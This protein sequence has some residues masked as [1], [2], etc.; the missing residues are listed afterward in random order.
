MKIKTLLLLFLIFSSSLFAQNSIA[1]RWTEHLVFA[2]RNDFARPTVHSRNLFHAS[3]VMYDAWAAYENDADFYLLGK[4]FGNFQ[5]LYE[6]VPSVADK[7]AAQEEAISFAMYRLLMHRFQNSP[8]L[9]VTFANVNAF[10]DSLGY[11]KTNI[12][13][14][15]IHGGPAELGNY[16]ADR[17]IAYGYLDGSNEVGGYSN[18]YYQP[19]QD[20][21]QVEQP[22]NPNMIDPNHWQ[23]I[24]LSYAVDQAGNVLSSD[25]PFLS[26]EWGN[27]VPFALQDSVKSTYSRAGHNYNVYHDPGAPASLDTNVV[28]QLDSY[29]KWNFSLVSV[30]QSHLDPADTTIWDI[31]PASLGNISTYPTQFSDYPNFYNYF[32]GGDI[33]QGYAL[34]PVTGAPYTPQLVKRADYARVIAEFWADGLSSETPPGHW[35]VIYNQVSNHPLYEKKWKGQGATLNDLEYDVKAYLTLGGALYD[36]GICAWGIKGWYDYV[37]PVSAL[38]YMAEKGQSS[39][40]TL[41][42]YHPA[43]LPLVPGYIEIVELGDPLAGASNQHVGKIKLYTWKGPT[44]ISN[45]ATTYAGVDWI[46][47]ENWW[48]YQRP[49]F[50]TPPFAGYV[51]GHSTFSRAAAE[52]M[53]FITGNPFFPGGMSNFVALQNDFLEFEDGPSADVILQWASYRDASDQCSLSRIWGEFILQ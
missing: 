35:F 12:S 31:S 46:L 24:S 10:M 37:R 7:Q 48:P 21:I 33:G 17:M 44:Y 41:A 53:T 29:Y 16:I 22:G 49:S 19:I 40:D 28:S 8:G 20:R 6:G 11:D 34:N 39:I 1:K 51:S 25:P 14:D 26:P 47:A 5:V 50:V 42:N 30:W 36:A 43:G 27:V 4:T 23:A 2:V 38:R 9:G 18:L 45:P 52:V 13:K 3:I 32:E 15:Y